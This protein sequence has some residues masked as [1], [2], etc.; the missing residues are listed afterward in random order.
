LCGLVGIAG[1]TI[2]VWK[3]IFAE[4]LL[5]DSVR[6]THSTGAGFVHRHNSEFRLAKEPGNPFNLFDKKEYDDCM[7]VNNPSRVLMGHNRF[8]TI[9]EH[10]ELNAHPF[11]FEHVMGAHNG[12]LDKFTIPNLHNHNHYGTDSEAI[13]ATINEVGVADTMKL[14]SGAWALVWF[15]KRDM[16]LN[17]LRN[18]KRPLH[19]C[20]SEDRTTLVWGSE[21]SMLRYVLGRRGKKVPEYFTVTPD[22]HYKWHVPTAF[23]KKFDSPVRTK[24]EGKSY[25]HAHVPFT[26]TSWRGSHTVTNTGTKKN[27]VFDFSK[28]FDV[29][30]FRPPYK[31]LYGHIINKKQ[32]EEMVSEGCSFC[33]DTDIKWGEFVQ[34]MGT[35]HGPKQTPFMCA[36]CYQDVDARDLL[37]Q[38]L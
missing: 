3:D 30:K 25:F 10:S 14:V 9:G 8:A 28:K 12:T 26:D 18:D 24:V 19:Y 16:T 2:G 34:I 22:L 33:N 7:S 29:N 31:D 38:L 32:L 6:G 13:F 4:L 1:D 23:N 36:E 17:F 37:P 5:V 11:A 35:W 15:D 21:S 27:N 20:Y